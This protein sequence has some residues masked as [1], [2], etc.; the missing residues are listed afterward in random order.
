MKENVFNQFIVCLQ[1][2]EEQGI[3]YSL[4]HHR[5]EA[6]MVTVPGERWE[7]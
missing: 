6:V 5:D 1:K 4:A 2:L 3:S 7:I